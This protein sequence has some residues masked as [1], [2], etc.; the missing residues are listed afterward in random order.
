MEI[1]TIKTAG[2]NLQEVALSKIGGKGFSS[3]SGNLLAGDVDFAVHSLKDVPAAVPEG[4]VVGVIPKREDPRDVLIS[5]QRLT[6]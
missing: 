3:E 1:V 6:R 4:L 2:D 5:R